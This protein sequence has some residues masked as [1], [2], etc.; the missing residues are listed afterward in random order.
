MGEQKVLRSIDEAPGLSHIGVLERSGRYAWG[1]GEH[2]FQRLKD[3]QGYVANLR[4]KG[5]TD[6]EIAQGSGMS[7]DEF[8][9]SLVSTTT[10]RAK[11]TIRNAQERVENIAHAWELKNR[12]WS[13]VAIAEAMGV[14]ESVV[15]TWL[16]PGADAK[17]KHTL[18]V[19]ETFKKAVA[20]RGIIDVGGGV[21]LG[22]G[23]SKTRM[24][25]C[26]EL[27]KEEGYNV[28]WTKVTQAGTGKET[29]IRA[30]CPPDM[31]Y[32]TFYAMYSADPSIVK[33]VGVYAEETGGTLQ[34]IGKPTSISRDRVQI[35]FNEEGGSEKDGVIELRPGVEDLDLL[36]TKYAQVR[37]GINDTMYMKGMA[38][39]GDPKDFK[40]GCDVIYNV[41]RSKGSPDLS[42]GVKEGVFKPMYKKG[43]EDAFGASTSLKDI[44]EETG[45][46]IYQKTYI[47][48]DGKQHKSALN[49]VN[50]QGAWEEWSPSLASQFLSKQ[51]PDLAKKQLGIV[52]KSKEDELNEIL[53]LNNPTVRKKLLEEFADSC[54]SAAVHLKA[55]ALPRQKSQV[56]LPINSLAENEIYAPNFR[57]GETVVLVRY[58]HAGPMESPELKV[59]NKNPEGQRI[60]GKST[61]GGRALDAV[62]I[63]YNTAKQLSGAD[64]DGDSVLVLPN[65]DGVIKTEKY[66]KGLKNFDPNVYRLSEGSPELTRDPKKRER[67]KQM[68][69]G[70]VSNLIT[71]MTIQG[72]SEAELTRAIK[73]SMVVIDCVKHNLDYKA[74]YK[75][76]GIQELKNKYQAK[77]GKEKGGGSATL[78]SRAKN[79]QRVLER[80][81]VYSTKQMTPEEEK[82]YHELRKTDPVAAS[83][84][85]GLTKAEKAAYDR[86][87]IVYRQTGRTKMVRNEA[88]EWVDSGKLVTQKSGKMREAKNAH[89]LSSGTRIEEIYAD[90]ANKLKSLANQARVASRTTP[91]LQQSPSAKEVYAEEVK[92]L[93]S[94][95]TTAQMNRPVERQAQLVASAAMKAKIAANPELKEDRDAYKKAYNK[96]LTTARLMTGANKSAVAVKITDKEWNAI[97][98]GAISDNMLQEILKNTDMDAVKKKAT[99]RASVGLSS[100]QISRAKAMAANGLTQAEIA[101]ALGVSTSTINSA[102][103]A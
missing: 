12:G 95:L 30:L 89:T 79:E 99:P 18:E 88:G 37:I 2:P 85:T 86:G 102:L 83:K 98:A 53:S 55:A 96:A 91:K 78:I 6:E 67:T 76:N 38:I 87:E 44:D 60:I 66:Y 84:M 45:D 23:V 92:S 77:E 13:N 42:D 24:D 82:R 34:P 22:L 27:L 49:I 90:H 58:P 4:R 43:S 48:S 93:K 33:P 29:T 3:W 1:S 72:A 46:I 21:E 65:N 71:D 7:I 11:K 41:N 10:S 100:A 31:D 39:Y 61:A 40:P 28:Y 32:K 9:D 50:D 5:M 80:K 25:A 35:R 70:I 8:R 101:D 16:K 97:Q 47:G 15:R 51:S 20:E 68:E 56:I 74:S 63:N 94:K 62:G 14:N 103:K 75:E 69:M 52:S 57:D 54:D 64:F 19:A 81:M 73:H 36:G 59:N 26:L 17:A